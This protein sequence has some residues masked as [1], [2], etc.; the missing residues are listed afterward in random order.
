MRFFMPSKRTEIISSTL[1][2]STTIKSSTKKPLVGF[3]LQCRTPEERFRRSFIC[4]LYIYVKLAFTE[5]PLLRYLS[6]RHKSCIA[7]GIIPS[8]SSA[9][10][11]SR[12]KIS[13]LPAIVYVLPEPVWPYA[14][15]VA[16]YP[17][18]AASIN[19]STRHF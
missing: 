9:L 7:L 18:I 11:T 2:Q 14:K 5:Y 10:Y 12:A 19:S 6:L 16:E 4:S 13:Y 17:S 1:L 15:T 3:H 8:R